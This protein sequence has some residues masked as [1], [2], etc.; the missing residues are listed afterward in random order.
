MLVRDANQLRVLVLLLNGRS[1]VVEDPIRVR[2]TKGSFEQ[3]LLWMLGL[4]QE[5]GGEV[6]LSFPGSEIVDGRLLK[7]EIEEES[8]K[9]ALT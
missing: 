3:G 5:G 8:K 7:E 9:G 1:G 4:G 2:F 6:G